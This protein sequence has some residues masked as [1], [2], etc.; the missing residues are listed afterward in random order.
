MIRC[1]GRILTAVRIT[2][3]TI[4]VLNSVRN[5]DLSDSSINDRSVNGSSRG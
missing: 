1:F 5:F 4:D 3:I 2:G